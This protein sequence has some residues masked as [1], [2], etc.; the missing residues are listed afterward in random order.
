[1]PKNKNTSS[2]RF[3]SDAHEKSICKAL[4]AKQQS[5]SGAGHFNKGDVVHESAS[6][7]IE[8][9]C[10]MKPKDSVSVKREW[11]EKNKSEGFAIRKANQAVCINFEPDGNNYYLIN[12]RLMKFLVEKLEEEN[13]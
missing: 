9:K 7:L 11:V 8:A 13:S 5:N 6:L 4:G 3:Y 2:T 12:E 10:C 1:M